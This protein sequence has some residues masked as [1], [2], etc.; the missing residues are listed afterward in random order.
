VIAWVLADATQHQ[1]SPHVAEEEIRKEELSELR[2]PGSQYA[3]GSSRS[4]A[5]RDR[6]PTRPT[7]TRRPS[8]APAVSPRRSPPLGCHAG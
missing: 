2:M 5:V 1:A 4:D 3:C 7:P 8:P 6:R